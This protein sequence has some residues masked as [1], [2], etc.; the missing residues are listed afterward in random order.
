MSEKTYGFMSYV[1][2]TESIQKQDIMNVI[3][4]NKL[5]T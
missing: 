3:K 5:K 4:N 2:T 1:K